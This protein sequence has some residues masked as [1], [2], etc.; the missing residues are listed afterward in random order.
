VPAAVLVERR[1]VVEVDIREPVALLLLEVDAGTAPLEARKLRGDGLLE[2]RVLVAVLVNE[3]EARV[4]GS[5]LQRPDFPDANLSCRHVVVFP[6][7]VL[8]YTRASP[9]GWGSLP[10]TR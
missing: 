3:D 7:A 10:A 1:H 4:P 9:P 6:D 5:G 2:R 8:L